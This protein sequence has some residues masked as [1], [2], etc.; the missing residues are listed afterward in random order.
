MI[1]SWKVPESRVSEVVCM[2]ICPFEQTL[3]IGL[4]NNTIAMIKM[5]DLSKENEEMV[6]N[7][8]E[9]FNFVH[10]GYHQSQISSMD[11]CLHRPIIATLSKAEKTI[12]L[13]N[14]KNPKCE[15]I[16]KFDTKIDGIE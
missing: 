4:A 16:K 6:M 12:R 15:L 9:L 13:W 5:K 7:D 8:E 14:Y 10:E 2:D 3:G 11:V 1:K